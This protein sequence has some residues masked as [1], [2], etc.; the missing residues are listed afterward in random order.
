M[1]TALLS[2]VTIGHIGIIEG[3]FVHSLTGIY[4]LCVYVCVWFV[5]VYIGKVEVNRRQ[6]K[7]VT[8]I[9]G[10]ISTARSL[11]RF[12]LVGT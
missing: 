11:R 12:I 9:Y 2:C 7:E 4:D 8:M 10:Q 3:V 6:E 5:Y 1:T